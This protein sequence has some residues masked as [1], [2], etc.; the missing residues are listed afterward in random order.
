M[1]I[2]ILQKLPFWAGIFAA[3][4]AL[5]TLLASI[6]LFHRGTSIALP[7][8]SLPVSSEQP[9]NVATL[10][11]SGQLTIWD[12]RVSA[13]LLSMPSQP[14]KLYFLERGNTL[15]LIQ[16]DGTIRCWHAKEPEDG[17]LSL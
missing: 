16:N 7:E 10:S 9:R 4:F 14:G 6:Y 12:A 15:A 1:K 17:D 2:T 8:A 13:P 3:T 5:T 11:T